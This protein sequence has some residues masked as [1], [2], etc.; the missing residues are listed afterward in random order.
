MTSEDFANSKYKPYAMPEPFGAGNSANYVMPGASSA[1]GHFNF[2]DGFDSAFGA[3]K[4]NNG[5]Y[6]TRTQMN[7]IGN[8]ATRYEFFRRVGGIVTFDPDLSTAIGGYPRGAILECLSS[9]DIMKVIS[10]VDN[11][12]YDFNENGIDNVHWAVLNSEEAFGSYLIKDVSIP[13]IGST[14]LATFRAPRAGS[15]RV[16]SNIKSVHT[17]SYTLTVPVGSTSFF[18]QDNYAVLI[19]DLGSGST[20]SSIQLPVVT[21]SGIALPT[22]NWNGNQALIG[23]GGYLCMYDNS[24]WQVKDDVPSA[25]NLYVAKDKWYGISLLNYFG[26]NLTLV[27]SAAGSPA[28]ISVQQFTLE[29]TFSLMYTD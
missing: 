27:S 21:A 15:L 3:P 12:E 14:V 26:E 2:A 22:V 9:S 13:E 6:V 11:N 25:S 18:R 28:E 29:G 20:P 4:S 23:G 16:V 19:A 17:G 1:A 10:L 7:G 5:Q 8:L 24:G